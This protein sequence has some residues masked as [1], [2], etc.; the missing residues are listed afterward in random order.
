MTAGGRPGNS[1][2]SP[3]GTV[4]RERL[5]E[6]LGQPDEETPER[7]RLLYAIVALRLGLGLLFL[8]RGWEGV[9]ASS[10]TSFAARLGAP[11]WWGLSGLATDTV[12]FILGCTELGIGPLLIFGAF[13]RVSAVTGLV[14]ATFYLIFGQ[15]AATAQCPYPSGCTRSPFDDLVERSSLIFVIGGLLVL[16]FCGS[17]FLGADRALDKLEEEERDRAPAR[18]PRLA[19]MTPLFLRLSWIFASLFVTAYS[20]G[21]GLRPLI[22]GEIANTHTFIPSG[23]FLAL[24]LLIG[25]GWRIVLGF[26]AAYLLL[27]L[28]MA[29]NAG[30]I[31]PIDTNWLLAPLTSLTAAFIVGPGLWRIAAPESPRNAASDAEQID[32]C[33]L[34]PV[35]NEPS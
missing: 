32:E 11:G 33:D 34:S 27:N 23:I 4:F 3:S 20:A 21:L 30:G 16:V 7:R 10:L 17:P 26:S 1:A 15:F 29:I 35:D 31:P 25:F 12:L 19:M 5:W 28:V 13:T 8:L 9:F 22:L 6:Y 24:L 18:L 2:T 14:L